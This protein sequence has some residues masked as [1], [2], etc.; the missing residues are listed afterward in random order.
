MVPYEVDALAKVMQLHDP[1]L[2]PKI[3][4][5]K[6]IQ[7]RQ[8]HAG[9]MN[10]ATFSRLRDGSWGVRVNGAAAKGDVVLASRRDGRQTCLTVGAVVWSGNGV[11][12]ARIDDTR[13]SEPAPAPVCDFSDCP[14]AAD[15]F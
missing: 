13:K 15:E 4:K 10:T 8:R 12:L 3:D 6:L 11:T 7:L 1:S 2:H 14:A 9:N 5:P